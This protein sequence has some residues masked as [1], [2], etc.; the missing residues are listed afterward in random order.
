MTSTVSSKMNATAC[1]SCGHSPLEIIWNAGPTPIANRFYPDPASERLT[2]PFVLA[3]CPKC[4]LLQLVAPAPPIHLRRQAAW[5][6]YN[7]PEPHLDAWTQRTAASF[8]DACKGTILGAG[9]VDATT[10]SRFQKMGLNAHTLDF[11]HDF[12]ITDPLAGTETLQAAVSAKSAEKIRQ[13]RGPSSVLVARYLL[14]HMHNLPQFFAFASTL[15]DGD[16]LLLLE[17]PD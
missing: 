17:V 6:H 14:E 10:I 1:S 11:A 16:G 8:P 9:P 2:H 13:E 3:L 7:E 5:I 15:L 12:G 4:A